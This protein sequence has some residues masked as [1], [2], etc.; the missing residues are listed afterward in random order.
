MTADIIEEENQPLVLCVLLW[1]F[2]GRE[3]QLTAYEDE[4]LELVGDHDG[5]VLQRLRT[6][7]TDEGPTEVQVI[8]FGSQAALDGYMADERRLALAPQ[9]DLAIRRTE[10][11]EA[12][13]LV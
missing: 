5:E 3:D 2:D 11:M 9:R 7:A 4:V 10:V 6:T 13:L 1:A 12:T 8:R